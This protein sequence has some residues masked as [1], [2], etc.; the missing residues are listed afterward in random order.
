MHNEVYRICLRYRELSKNNDYAARNFQFINSKVRTLPMLA[1]VVVPMRLEPVPVDALWGEVLQEENIS[2]DDSYVECIKMPLLHAGD[3]TCEELDHFNRIY[4]CATRNAVTWEFKPKWLYQ[5]TDYCRNCTHNA[6]KGRDI[7]YCFLDDPEL[8]VETLFRNCD[9]P[10]EFLHDVV[11]YLRSTDSVTR[12]LFAA[13]EL[14]KD[15]LATLMTLRDVTCFLT[16]SRAERSIGASIIDV[17]QKP[18]E[19]LRHWQDTEM[20]LASFP[21]KKK[22]HHGL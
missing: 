4:Q 14:V 16:W 15:D 21:E 8:V 12:R 18:E 10:L 9:V 11:K 5:S 22:A 20:A 3:S 13:Q 7:Q 6:W 17:D 1:D 19:K 2:I